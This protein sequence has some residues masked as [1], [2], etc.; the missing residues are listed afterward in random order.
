[1]INQKGELV[2]IVFDGNIESLAGRFFFDPENNRAVSVHSAYVLEA[3]QKL[4]DASDLADELDT[5]P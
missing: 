5:W 4:Y 2:G 1:V 3:L